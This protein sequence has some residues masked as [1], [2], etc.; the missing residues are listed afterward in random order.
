MTAHKHILAG[1]WKMKLTADKATLLAKGLVQLSS[2]LRQ[3][4][5]WVAP[6]FLAIP[7]VA[8]VVQGSSI[9][10]GAQNVH[11]SPEGAFT[12]EVSVNMLKEFGCQFAIVGHSERR[13]IFNESSELVASRAIPVIK[14]RFQVVF[15]V[16][17]TLDQRKQGITHAILEQQMSPLLSGLAEEDSSSLA[18]AYEP[19]WAIGTGIVAKTDEIAD[20][21]QAVANIWASHFKTP[22]PAIL[23]G[24]SVAPN[25]FAEILRV[26]RVA[27][28]LIGG[29]SLT[30]ES[31]QALASIAEEAALK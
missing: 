17:E 21:H 5:I 2:K 6:S 29:A 25:N 9:R 8:S 22:P 11:G 4:E 28:A 27:G 31:M 7:S 1:N 26:P 16:G 12:G 10:L 14:L 20:A 15:C 19:V 30:I 24:G 18:F 23:Y 3:S 13:N